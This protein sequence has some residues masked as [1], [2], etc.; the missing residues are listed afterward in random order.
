MIIFL[1]LAGHLAVAYWHL[2]LAWRF[3][4]QRRENYFVHLFW[5]LMV[6]SFLL[7]GIYAAYYLAPLVNQ[8]NISKP[9]LIIGYLLLPFLPAILA[10]LF[11][12][13]LTEQPQKPNLI[14]KTLAFISKDTKKLFI[15]CL[16]LPIISIINPIV[17][18]LTIGHT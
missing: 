17:T 11:L 6:L 10:T 4:P 18:E 9:L 3:Y 8:N 16:S 5:Y 12:G 1:S 2:L 13:E 14:S 7:H 15:V